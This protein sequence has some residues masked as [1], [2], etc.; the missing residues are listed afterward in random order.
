M[1]HAFRKKNPNNVA[2]FKP[3]YL[4]IQIY[5]ENK[6]VS[7]SELQLKLKGAAICQNEIVVFIQNSTP[8]DLSVTTIKPH[9][10]PEG[11]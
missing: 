7:E 1:L 11:T 6:F 3:G 4:P 8:K 2:T 5:K 10:I 9:N